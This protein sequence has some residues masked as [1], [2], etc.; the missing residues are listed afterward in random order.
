MWPLRG[1][2]LPLGFQLTVPFRQAKG[3]GMQISGSLD[4]SIRGINENFL[5]LFLFS[6][7][8]FFL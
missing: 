5:L 7:F 4:A 3:A 1:L 2:W 6:F 8:L